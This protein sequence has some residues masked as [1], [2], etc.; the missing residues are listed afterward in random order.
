MHVGACAIERDCFL[1]NVADKKSDGR[2]PQEKRHEATFYGPAIS[3]GV[4]ADER[5]LRIHQFGNRVLH[6]VS[7]SYVQKTER[8]WSG[9]DCRY[10]GL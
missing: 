5:K 10:H 8:G 4:K 1:H 7:V 6:G 9:D 3:F 2:A